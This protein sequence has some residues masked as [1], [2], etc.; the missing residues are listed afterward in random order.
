MQE[1]VKSSCRINI[2]F[3][4]LNASRRNAG[5]F[6]C[7]GII[8]NLCN[9][10]HHWTCKVVTCSPGTSSHAILKSIESQR[11]RITGGERKRNSRDE[12]EEGRKEK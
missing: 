10:V 2:I 5:G 9:C 6:L 11:V 7:R 3:G 12:G 1:M 8:I 4:T